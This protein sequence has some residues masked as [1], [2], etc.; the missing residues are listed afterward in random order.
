MPFLALVHLREL[1]CGRCRSLLA[2][3]GA[4]SFIVDERGEAFNVSS[5]AP[6]E[7]MRVTIVCPCGHH[8]VLAVPSE[9]GAEE[10][11]HT[12]DDAPI[13]RDAMIVA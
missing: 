11:L 4:R 10:T 3:A 13:G 1:R 8:T 7:D 6:P 12:P 5:E 2:A 9:I